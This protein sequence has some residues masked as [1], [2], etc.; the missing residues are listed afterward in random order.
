MLL[1]KMIAVGSVVLLSAGSA[2]MASADTYVSVFGGYTDVDDLD[3]TVAPSSRV[4]TDFDGGYGLGV[5]MGRRL[6]LPGANN[7]WRV[8]TEVTYR[9]NDVDSHKLNGGQLAGPGGRIDSWSL[10]VNGLIDFNEP[11]TF[12][13][14]IGAGFGIADVHAKDFRAAA[15]PV[16]LDDS[17]AVFA[18]QFIAGAG[19][20]VSQRTELLAEYRYFATDDPGV[21][22]SP[23]T[24]SLPNDI[25][26]ESH[27]F[28]IGARFKF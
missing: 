17:D 13:P 21:T 27:N 28:I 24:G 7:R 22:T 2:S 8:E 11:S 23:P 12:T 6:G 16:V 19:Y 9:R 4:D 18:Y 3:F 20:D 5:A 1:R 25:S 10:M 14:Y 26:Y 15:I